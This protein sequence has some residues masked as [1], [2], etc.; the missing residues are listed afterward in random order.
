MRPAERDPALLDYIQESIARVEQYSRAGHAAF[1]H[2]PI[3]QDAILRRLETLSDA[4]SRLS[5]ELKAR[6]PDLPWRKIYGF[7]NVA[8]HDY[9][10]LDLDLAVV[11]QTVEEHLPALKAVVDE[12]LGRLS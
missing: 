4:A 8:A 11:W 9:L 1:L 12:E 7:R 10:N 3:V 5:D 6:H 2:E